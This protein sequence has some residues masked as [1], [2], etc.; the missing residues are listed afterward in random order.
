MGES[1][2]ITSSQPPIMA[3]QGVLSVV[4]ET[5][6]VIVQGVYELFEKERST[7][8]LDQTRLNRMV[9]IGTYIQIHTLILTFTAGYNLDRDILLQSFKKFCL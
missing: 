1:T 4:G 6:Q 2:S 3:M 5:R 9:F 8:W 7:E